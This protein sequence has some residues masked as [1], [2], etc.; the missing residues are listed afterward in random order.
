MSEDKTASMVEVDDENAET[1]ELVAKDVEEE[2]GKSLYSADMVK[3][4][5][6]K[7]YEKMTMKSSVV[8]SHHQEHY[9]FKWVRPLAV[10]FVTSMILIFNVCSLPWPGTHKMLM[11]MNELNATR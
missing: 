10:E 1:L 6:V 3:H 9:Y 7:Y 2:S 4:S 5:V 8:K 11:E